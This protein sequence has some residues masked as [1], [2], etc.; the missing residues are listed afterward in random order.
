MNTTVTGGN[1]ITKLANELAQYAVLTGQDT[2]YV[3][4]SLFTS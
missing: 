2:G 4:L 3:L 1:F